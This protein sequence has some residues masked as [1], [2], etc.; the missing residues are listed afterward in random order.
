MSDCAL[1]RKIQV[2]GDH[3]GP[4]LLITGGVHGDEFEPI[5]AIHRLR[6]VVD[7]QAVWGKVTLVPVAN[8]TAF[9]CGTRDGEDG[10]NLARVCPGSPTGAI[11]ER[12]AHELSDLIRTADY[13]IDLHTGGSWMKI[14]PLAGYFLHSD[15][16]ILDWQRK[17]AAAFNLPC[18]WG[19]TPAL[20]GRT[21]S[22]ARDAN[23][24]AIYTEYHGAATC[25]PEGTNDYVEG[26]LNV[27][28]L[29]GM[30]DREVVPSKTKWVVEDSCEGGGIFD[31]SYVTPSTGFFEP[32]VQLGEQVKSGDRLGHVFDILGDEITTIRTESC[33]VVLG[34]RTFSRVLAGDSVAVLLPYDPARE[35]ADLSSA[36]VEAYGS[37]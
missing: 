21:I 18:I 1:L 2:Q 32:D 36:L 15:P 23:I 34:L 11:T 6:R 37:E 25:D 30:I 35:V 5:A 3:D 20:Q 9:I 31:E 4:H 8:E 28:A 26:C 33:G 22:V 17:M 19:T 29:L 24:P 13:Y 10:I 12:V 7:P 14:L 27:M 16:V